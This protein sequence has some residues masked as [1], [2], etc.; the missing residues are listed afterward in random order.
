MSSLQQQAT[1]MM[2]GTATGGVAVGPSF[3]WQPTD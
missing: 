3:E 2:A 1:D